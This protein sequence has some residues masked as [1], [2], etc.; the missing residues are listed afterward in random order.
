MAGQPRD[1]FLIRVPMEHPRWRHRA[2][3]LRRFRW[4][5]T[6]H[7]ALPQYPACS[8]ANVEPR[9]AWRLYPWALHRAILGSALR[10]PAP[11]LGGLARVCQPHNHR[12]R[13]REARHRNDVKSRRFTGFRPGPPRP[14][15]DSAG[16]MH[17][18]ATLRKPVIVSPRSWQYSTQVSHIL[19]EELDCTFY[20]PQTPY[21]KA[22]RVR[23]TCEKT[24]RCN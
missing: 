6:I 11:S 4:P 2:C 18:P 23:S 24:L 22:T 7:P 15:P 1:A 9:C 14:Y 8:R 10:A 13:C 3:G 5:L 20:E 12:S 17:E 19:C 16:A 21:Y